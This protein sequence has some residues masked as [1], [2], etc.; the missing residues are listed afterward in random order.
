MSWFRK[1]IEH[2]GVVFLD[3]P[4]QPKPEMFHE[5][6]RCGIDVNPG[7]PGRDVLWS[8]ELRHPEWGDAVLECMSNFEAPGLDDLAMV[9][10]LTKTEIG[11]FGRARSWLALRHGASAGHL[12]RDRKRFLRFAFAALSDK[13]PGI[14]DMLS[15]GY[16]SK[17]A[18][19]EELSHDADLD[20][21][22]LFV[23]HAVQD[24]DDPDAVVWAH[25]HGLSELGH[26]DVDVLSPSGDTCSA[27]HELFRTVAAAVL[28]ETARC[29]GEPVS[30]FRPGGP[31]RFVSAR[32]FL[33][34]ARPGHT[35]AYSKL[36]TDT[37]LHGHAVACEPGPGFAGRLL[38]GSGPRPC[39]WLS[40]PWAEEGMCFHSPGMTGLMA[41]RA[42]ATMGLFNAWRAEFAP[43][44][45]RGLV[46][47]GYETDGD[48]Q[49]AEHLWF[50][51]HGIEDDRVDATLLNEP[52]DIS[53]MRANERGWH[54]LER[55][56]DW[57]IMLPFGQLTPRSLP[58][59]RTIRENRGVILEA[60]KKSGA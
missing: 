18:L 7:K 34:Q 15:G 31:V 45:P 54:A 4:G 3:Q 40:Q 48:P 42:R 51:V 27:R 11:D 12:L 16:W 52:Y 9:S 24:E 39:R 10:N 57:S 36:L 37:H 17:C 41:E 46:K 60:M 6:A 13:G 25:T 43:F 59:A 23:I 2:S 58:F 20:V 30:L 19:E 49:H 26:F 1:K 14:K 35:A 32:R 55:L 44:D 5:L 53:R 28:E 38:R 22:H 8:L 56:T 29:D 50:E 21:D 33:A 47:I